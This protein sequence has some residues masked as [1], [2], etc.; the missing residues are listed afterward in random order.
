V[1]VHN[2]EIRTEQGEE[3]PEGVRAV[4]LI[5]EEDCPRCQEI[6]RQLERGMS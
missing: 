2:H 6:R 3:S 4:V 5:L 1:T